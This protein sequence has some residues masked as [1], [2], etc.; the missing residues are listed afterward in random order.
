MIFPYII[1]CYILINISS[2]NRKN[3][4]VK[5]LVICILHSLKVYDAFTEK[6]KMYL[7]LK[8]SNL[9]RNSFPCMKSKIEIREECGI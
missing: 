8:V 7:C 6:I 3:A 9:N 4:Q 5:A 1:Y 2:F